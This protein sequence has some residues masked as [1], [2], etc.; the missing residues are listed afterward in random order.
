MEE[1]NKIE[2]DKTIEG[3]LQTFNDSGTSDYLVVYLRLIVS[4][5]LQRNEDFYQ[6]FLD[7][8]RTMKDFCNQVIK[9]VY[10]YF[11]FILK[12]FVL[13]RKWNLWVERVITFI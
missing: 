4:G 5:Y 1:L 2:K 10:L 8:G 7:G 3:V 12:F 9:K 13:I 11:Y 6:S